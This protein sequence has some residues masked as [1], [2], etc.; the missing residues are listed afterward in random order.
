[1]PKHTFTRSERLKSQKAINALFQQGWAFSH[2][3][4]RVIYRLEPES[5]HST[6]KVLV[7]VPKRRYPKAVHRNRI[8]RQIKEAWRLNKQ[9]LYNQLPTSIH[10]QV[11]IVYIGK[12]P[13]PYPQIDKA[14]KGAMARLARKLKSNK[15]P[16][17]T[18][19]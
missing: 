15:P 18:N 3:P 11:A 19:R 12:T 6:T 9:N 1:M 17:P 10:C 7:S 8:R 14:M 4:L 5:D 2:Y 13:L 16:D